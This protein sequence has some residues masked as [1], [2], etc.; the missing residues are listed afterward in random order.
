M[1]SCPFHSERTPSGRVYHS[2]ASRSPGFFKCYGCGVTKPWN[3]LAPALGLKPYTWTKPQEHK[4][5]KIIRKRETEERERTMVHGDLPRNKVWREIPTN[6]LISIGCRKSYWHYTDEDVKGKPFVY[7]PVEVLGELRGH[8]CAR[9]KKH[10][11]RPSYINASGGWSK[12]YGLFPY[13]YARSKSPTV[14]V[15]VEGPRDA[16]HLIKHGIMAVAILGTQAWSARKSRMIELMGV[17]HVVL[18]MD[19]DDAG[20]KA[21]ELIQPQLQH[22]VNTHVF[23]LTGKD[24]P[25]WKFRNKEEP[26]K[27]AKA[28]G[29]ELWDP[30]SLPAHKLE[31]LRALTRRLASSAGSMAA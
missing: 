2:S 18:C 31:Q 4:A 27:A 21:I 6:L 20:L 14:L 5:Y 17:T 8:I 22:L 25:Y 29:V 26:S 7:M 9:L 15:L 24:S 23:S 3:E 28:K 1:L 12:D 30:Q 11:D 19:G 13:D 10:P 16:L